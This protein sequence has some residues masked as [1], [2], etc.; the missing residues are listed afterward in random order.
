[1]VLQDG[2]E[3]IP[4]PAQN[5]ESFGSGMQ[6]T[7]MRNVEGGMNVLTDNQSG[8]GVQIHSPRSPE[9]SPEAPK[10]FDDQANSLW[11][12]YEKEARSHDEARI[13]SLKDDMDGVLIFVCIFDHL[14]S[15]VRQIDVIFAPGWPILRGSHVVRRPKDSGLR[16]EPHISIGLLPEPIPSS[17]RSDI[18]TTRINWDTD[19]FQ[20]HPTI[21]S[22]Y[23]S[24]IGF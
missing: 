13:Q 10:D 18:A 22:S 16:S 2:Q 15:E 24:T 3:I 9:V 19:P 1:M 20:C 5:M 4:V 6:P 8:S 23:L 14:Q 7:S 21:T 17:S 11:Y 12:L